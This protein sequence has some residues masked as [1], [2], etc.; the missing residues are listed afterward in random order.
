MWLVLLGQPEVHWVEVS[1]GPQTFQGTSQGA[2][3]VSQRGKCCLPPVKN[4][5]SYQDSGWK[6]KGA[7]LERREA[8]EVRSVCVGQLTE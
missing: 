5:S 4:F 7:R 2:S 1:R 6:G 8:R 3:P